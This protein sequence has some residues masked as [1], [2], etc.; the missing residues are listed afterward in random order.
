MKSAS[1]GR[2]E[3]IKV[4]DNTRVIER[5]LMQNTGEHTRML[6]AKE[7][8]ITDESVYEELRL[9]T[10]EM[11]MWLMK[12]SS[13]FAKFRTKKEESGGE[14]KATIQMTEEDLNNAWDAIQMEEQK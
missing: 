1:K 2:E 10:E 6:G 11:A 13:E 3:Y 14:K 9:E 5:L 7:Y 8:E 4:A 12:R